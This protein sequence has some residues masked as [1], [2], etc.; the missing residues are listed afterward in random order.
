LRK[1]VGGAGFGV[2]FPYEEAPADQSC[3]GGLRSAHGLACSS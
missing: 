1:Y 3:R 2:K